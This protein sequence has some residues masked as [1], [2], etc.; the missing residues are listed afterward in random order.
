MKKILVLTIL[1]STAFSLSA[2]PTAEDTLAFYKTQVRSFSEK[3]SAQDKALA[4]TLADNLG[5][6][7]TQFS[8]Y[9]QVPEALLLQTQ[10]YLKADNAGAALVPLF[11]L[12]K[13]YAPAQ[14]PQDI[15]EQA[16]QGLH[17]NA[18][19]TARSNFM[20]KN[21]NSNATPEEKE[22]DALYVFSKLYGKDFY[23]PAAEAFENFFVR[24]PEYEQNDKVELWY[25]DLHR[26]NGNYLAAIAQCQKVFQL[27]PDTPYR[28]ASMRL[29][30]DIYADMKDTEKAMSAY[31]KVLR[32]F[33][34]SSE[35]GIV[36]KHMGMLEENNKQYDTALMDYNKAIELLGTSDA[37]YEA[38]YGK[39]DVYK[40]TKSFEEAYDTLQQTA[41]L[42]RKDPYKYVTA[43]TDAA[44]IA[45]R[46][47]KDE[48]KYVQSLEKALIAYPK[49]SRSAEI[50][51]DL[52]A[53]YEKRGQ[54]QKA[55]DM[56]HRLILQHPTDKL[57]NK[58][59]TRLSRLEK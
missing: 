39:A 29:T 53:V 23:Q 56:Y 51:Y 16:L 1:L 40:K 3:M 52:A 7:I 4:Q 11:R 8:E 10:L 21:A 6:W 41:N 13:L 30:G 17:R 31:A 18:R 37:A 9:K 38:Y 58:A 57:A 14:L 25:G 27:Y 45:K 19:E 15:L 36:F 22:A 33:P 12:Q 32:E 34:Q 28:A 42:F 46:N 5:T 43:L 59:Q 20:L 44:A 2:A 35:R 47:L 24:F 54:N 50:M 48:G 26:V 49:N 55:V